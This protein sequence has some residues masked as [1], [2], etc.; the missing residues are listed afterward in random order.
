MQD[1]QDLIL[2]RLVND[3]KFCRK[4]LPFLKSKYFEGKARHVFDLILSFVAKYNKLPNSTALEYEFV[5]SNAVAREG[6]E[7]EIETHNFI[8]ELFVSTDDDAKLDETWLLENTEKWCK[9]RAVY[10]AVIQS[11]NIIDGKDKQ[12]APGMIPE[13]LSK[14]LSVTFDRNIGH[15]YLDNSNSRFDFYHTKEDRIPFDL[16]MFN[17]ITGGG[18]PKKTLNVLIAGTGV[19]KSLA[20]CHLAAAY[21]DQGKNVLYITLEMAEERIAERID[22]NL[23]DTSIQ[24][25]VHLSKDE[26]KNKI[27]RIKSKTSGK[28]IIKEYPTASA[29]VGHFRGLVDELK[30]KKTFTPDVVFIDYLNICS[31]SRMRGLGGS[32]NSYSYVKAIAEEIRGLSIEL[33][34]PIWT[35]TQLN[36][37]G[38]KSSDVDLTNTSESFGLPATADFM[39]A[40]IS[41]EELEGLNQILVKQLKNRYNDMTKNRRF[42][43]GIDKSK[44][45]LYDVEQSAQD[46]LIPDI[47]EYTKNDGSD[48][49]NDFSDF[50][51]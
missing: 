16:T 8:K 14:A 1:L 34:V 17:T 23:F 31:S 37:E 20:M 27:S 28:L 47:V 39:C 36:R 40:L 12:H 46:D 5:N 25:L 32:I 30:L 9:D 49:S 29:H 33:N 4:T 48:S 50:K 35:A 2:K 43:L 24:N 26:F 11:I 51:V 44:M 45:R 21:L 6:K 42:M 7:F 13:L 38:F 18:V 3:E 19:G 22:A 41:S 15:D 10:L